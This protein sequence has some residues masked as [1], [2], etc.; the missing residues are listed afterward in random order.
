KTL[1]DLTLTIYNK[2]AEAA[3]LTGE[4]VLMQRYI[5]AVLTHGHTLLDKAQAYETQLQAAI[6]QGYFLQSIEVARHV[7]AQLDIEISRAPD[8]KLNEAILTETAQKLQQQLKQRKIESLV[9]HVPMHDPTAL[10][11]LRFLVK[12]AA[13]AYVTQPSL[14][15][16][17]VCLGVQRCLAFGNSPLS[18]LMYSW[19]GS[20]LCSMQGKTDAGQQMGTLA[21]ALLDKYPS[22]DV[23]IRVVA[24]VHHSI[25]PWKN[26]IKR[27]LSPLH[28]NYQLGLG[29]GDIEYAA[30]SAGLY[31][32]HAY[33]AGHN[34]GNLATKIGR[35]REG[36]SQHQQ[37]IAF[38]YISLYQQV[39]FNLLGLSES[40][41]EI[42]GEAYSETTALPIKIAVNDIIGLALFYCH[43]GILLTL[44]G[45]YVDAVA[46][47][48]K[49]R[50]YREG[51]ISSPIFPAMVFYESI[52]CLNLPNSDQIPRVIKNQQQL[53]QWAQN[54]PKNHLHRW[55]LVEAERA[56]RDH[57]KAAAIEHYDQAIALA[58]GSEFVQE[59]A[60]ANELAGEF[61]LQWNKTR[62]AE[63]YITDAYYAYSRWGA[64]AKINDLE[65]HYPK[66]LGEIL[67]QQNHS[68]DNTIVAALDYSKTHSSST[69]S[70][71]I[72]EVID[73]ATLLRTSQALSSEIELDK[74]L[75]TLLDAAIKNAGADKCIL[76]MPKKDKGDAVSSDTGSQDSA[77]TTF[78]KPKNGASSANEGDAEHKKK[79]KEESNEET[80][81]IEAFSNLSG[82]PMLLQSKRIEP[83]KDL[84]ITLVNQVKHTRKP[85][86]IFNAIAH[87]TFSVDPY[88]LRYHPKSVL[89]I[90][91]LNQG[92]LISILYLE[93]NLTI[94]AFTDQRVEVLKLICT[95][96]AISLENARLYRRTQQALE[97]L[98]ASHLQL[99]QSEKMSALGNLVSGIAHEI[100]N[101]V[102]FLKGNLKPA[103][104]YV[105][106]LLG[107]VDLVVE[108][109]PREVILEEI[110]DVNLE[111]IRE[112]LPNLLHSMRF[113][114]SRIRDISTSL[115]TFSRADKEYKTAF[116]LHDG[117]DST[118]LILKHRLRSGGSSPSI[119]VVKDYGNLPT[120]YCF[121]G[122]LNQVF[123]NLI[124]NAIDALE[125]A[126]S[127]RELSAIAEAPSQIT[128]ETALE[129]TS[130]V[131]ITISDNG[132]GIPKDIQSR[133]FDHLFTTKAVGKGTGLGLAISHNIITQKHSGTLNVRSE[134]GKGTAFVITLPVGECP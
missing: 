22:K 6:S 62:A 60:I 41:T 4:L 49:G 44:F 100:N 33:L 30:L 109:E 28:K 106:D 43:K 118:L 13:A 68:I 12:A 8:D 123:M 132:P 24:I 110:E 54:A 70:T 131:K 88:V 77:E 116:N 21:L 26:H 104:N 66:L 57:D 64:K 83:G 87:P 101:P 23:H 90:P 81:V 75:D 35:Y 111:F 37:E 34:L 31:G 10:V 98:Q 86:V 82:A 130:T 128:I 97:E 126:D 117:L 79:G 32:L 47:F 73:L 127:K 56:R 18:A 133:I 58:Q 72:S 20:L 112:D 2:A 102:N 17:I 114:I 76:L 52:A 27:S 50:Q 63:S 92:Q 45:E 103:I 9:D 124:A 36:I 48:E 61:Y 93:N 125:E 71:G 85:A 55:H 16:S 94:G 80:W 105:E 38:E 5:D 67:Q 84:P 119:E 120:I 89:C 96:A 122:Q 46:A 69:N 91:I 129:N 15:P 53:K 51:M 1:Y 25:R 107:I 29:N 65:K 74:L 59:S 39:T 11:V 121:A 7:L 95:Q 19:Y 42:E 40:P 3:L 134:V 14:M 115:R 108:E 99:V 78:P 113:G